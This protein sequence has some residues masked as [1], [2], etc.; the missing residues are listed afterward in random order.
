MERIKS[1]TDDGEIDAT[2]AGRRSLEIHATSVQTG[3]RFAYVIDHQA[4][5][6]LDRAEKGSLAQHILIG[7]VSRP[8]G[9]FVTGVVP[10]KKCSNCN[11]DLV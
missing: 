4:A 3:V 9:V 11:Q 7:P 10:V 5:G 1:L 8:I 6:V 2:V